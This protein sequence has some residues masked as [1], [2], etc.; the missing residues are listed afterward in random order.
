MRIFLLLA[1]VS[2]LFVASAPPSTR[3]KWPGA[4]RCTALRVFG[5]ANFPTP[6]PPCHAP[7]PFQRQSA[8]CSA[9]LFPGSHRAFSASPSPFWRK[10]PSARAP[11]FAPG[12]KEPSS[13]QN[14]ALGSA[15]PLAPAPICAATPSLE[16][17]SRLAESAPGTARRKAAT[18]GQNLRWATHAFCRLALCHRCRAERLPDQLRGL[19]VEGSGGPT[20]LSEHP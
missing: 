3:P 18:L 10:S 15:G 1:I 17:R 4:P 8:S 6:P 14:R 19:T 20:L 13:G 2:S 9:H 5:E 16:R 12:F 7:A 11:Q